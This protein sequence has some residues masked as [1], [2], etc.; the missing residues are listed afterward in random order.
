MVFHPSKRNKKISLAYFSCFFF[1]DFI[2]KTQIGYCQLENVYLLKY[3]APPQDST[4]LLSW[5]ARAYT[6]FEK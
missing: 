1:Y 3:V 2:I 4:G 5:G 6:P